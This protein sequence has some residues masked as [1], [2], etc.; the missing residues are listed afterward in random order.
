[1]RL[2]KQLV[3]LLYMSTRKSRKIFLKA[4]FT[5]RYAYGMSLLS[6]FSNSLEEGNEVSWAHRVLR[7]HTISEGLL[8]VCKVFSKYLQTIC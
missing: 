4:L 3:R 6:H 2:F 7:A 1:M 8:P 5:V